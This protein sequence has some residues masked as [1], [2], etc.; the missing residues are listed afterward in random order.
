MMDWDAWE[1]VLL[2]RSPTTIRELLQTPRA[3]NH[4]PIQ[5]R[6]TPDRLFPL[7]AAATAAITVYNNAMTAY[8]EQGGIQP[9]LP[10]LTTMDL[11]KDGKALYQEAM[12]NYKEEKKEWVM[13]DGEIGRCKEWI[14]SHTDTLLKE[15]NCDPNLPLSVW[16]TRLKEAIG[17]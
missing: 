12:A 1:R 13:M 14:L 2:A 10:P 6:I 7:T 3:D 4:R 15:A 9:V 11:T 5:P 17:Y 8:E 16:Y